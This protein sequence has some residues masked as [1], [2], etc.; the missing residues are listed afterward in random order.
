MRDITVQPPTA[1]DEQAAAFLDAIPAS[2]RDFCRTTSTGRGAV[3]KRWP[4]EPRARRM[5]AFDGVHMVGL[6]TTTP[7]NGG[8]RT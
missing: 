8:P 5:V 4:T 6:A 7:R 2:D 3:L 1:A